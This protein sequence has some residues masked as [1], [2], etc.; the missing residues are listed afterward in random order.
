MIVFFNVFIVLLNGV[1]F[2]FI[3]LYPDFYLSFFESLLILDNTIENRVSFFLIMKIFPFML[4]C[5]A[6]L[7][8]TKI[9]KESLKK[10]DFFD[11]FFIAG[12]LLFFGLSILEVV[13]EKELRFYD[14]IFRE[15]GILEYLTALF[16]LLASC[17]FLTNSLKKSPKLSMLY[18]GIS[19]FFFLFFLEELSWG[20]RIFDWSTPSYLQKINIQNETNIH[21]IFNYMFVFLY[22]LLTL[23]TALYFLYIKNILSFVKEKLN[24]KRDLMKYMPNNIVFSLIF[25]ITAIQGLCLT[26][27]ELAEQVFAF[28]GVMMGISIFDNR[29][30]QNIS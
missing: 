20:Q 3:F 10:I 22:P 17:L 9:K 24:L 16:A 29:S 28:T 23:I 25:V 14:F 21:N 27:T 19:I 2:F 7:I 6:I 12:F 18:L 13:L 15:D 30:K 26:S 5:I 1:N 8:G 4:T 11:I